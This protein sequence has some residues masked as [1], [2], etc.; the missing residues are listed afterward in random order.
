MVCGKAFRIVGWDCHRDFW[1]NFTWF[2]VC[3]FGLLDWILV[4]QVWYEISLLQ[5]LLP[6]SPPPPPAQV[7]VR[8]QICP[9]PLKT[10]D[11][12]RVQE[13]LRVVTGDSG[14]VGMCCVA[15]LLMLLLS[16][17]Y[18]YWS[19]YTYLFYH[20]RSQWTIDPLLTKPWIRKTVLQ[21][22]LQSART[23]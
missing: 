7:Q 21:F 6:P 15:F 18:C 23:R 19:I 22:P 14:G 9:W 13:I 12:T 1:G 2:C 17:S 4:I 3:F 16:T 8:W 5:P 10:D 11:V 20:R